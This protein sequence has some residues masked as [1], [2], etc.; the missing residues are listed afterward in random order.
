MAKLGGCQDL[1]QANTDQVP[2]PDAIMG[3]LTVPALQRPN[4]GDYT[5]GHKAPIQLSVLGEAW[6]MA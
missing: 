1:R 4:I 2:G 5:F 3:L 6:V